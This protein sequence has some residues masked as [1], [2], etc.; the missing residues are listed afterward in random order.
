MLD[1]IDM[2]SLPVW[3]RM[4]AIPK[5]AYTAKNTRQESP[6][7]LLREVGRGNPVMIR[8]YAFLLREVSLDKKVNNEARIRQIIDEVPCRGGEIVRM[9]EDA[10]WYEDGHCQMMSLQCGL[11]KST[12]ISYVIRDVLMCEEPERLLVVTDSIARLKGYLTPAQVTL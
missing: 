9:I 7:D 5:R 12:A 1:H 4:L 2:V 10:L 3:R 6:Y 11:G 8:R